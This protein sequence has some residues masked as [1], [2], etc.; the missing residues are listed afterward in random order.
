MEKRQ[1]G[2]FSFFVSLLENS[3]TQD[4]FLGY[5]AFVLCEILPLSILMW[6]FYLEKILIFS[7]AQNV[8]S[9]HFAF[10]RQR[11]KTPVPFFSLCGRRGRGGVFPLK[12]KQKGKH[13]LQVFS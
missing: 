9:K 13:E 6:S 8:S 10:W 4:T 11:K 3:F 12:T 1:K 2:I 7:N 5:H